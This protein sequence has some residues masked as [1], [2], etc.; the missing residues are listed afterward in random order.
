MLLHQLL[1]N[2][3]E[4]LTCFVNLSEQC[5]KLLLNQQQ[6]ENEGGGE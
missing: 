1:K 6:L 4:N 2:M 5:D 3:L